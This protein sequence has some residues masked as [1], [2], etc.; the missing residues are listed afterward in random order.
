MHKIIIQI[1]NSNFKEIL[2][3]TNDENFKI[4]KLKLSVL[5]P[6]FN[7]KDFDSIDKYISIQ[8]F[9]IDEKGNLEILSTIKFS[10]LYQI[11]KTTF[12]NHA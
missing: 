12:F 5:E 4:I 7:L 2:N 9:E 11:I 6:F 8:F 10:E 3:L 1:D